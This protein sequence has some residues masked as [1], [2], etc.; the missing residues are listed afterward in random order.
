MLP[1]GTIVMIHIETF[2]QPA[3]M[4]EDISIEGQLVLVLEELVPVEVIIGLVV[5]Y[6]TRPGAGEVDEVSPPGHTL[7]DSGER[8]FGYAVDVTELVNEG[9]H[10]IPQVHVLREGIVVLHI[11]ERLDMLTCLVVAEP[12]FHRTVDS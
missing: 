8:G 2:N 12:E 10:D 5:P 11:T 9:Q 1:G 6:S 4:G 3:V 7:R